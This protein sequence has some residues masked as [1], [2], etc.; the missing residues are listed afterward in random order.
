MKVVVPLLCDLLLNKIRVDRPRIGG[1]RRGYMNVLNRGH[2][3]GNAS[4]RRR[5]EPWASHVFPHWSTGDVGRR[6]KL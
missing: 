4:K 6:D 2:G 5:I 3:H 1:A